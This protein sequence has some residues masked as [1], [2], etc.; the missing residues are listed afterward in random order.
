[1]FHPVAVGKPFLRRR[2]IEGAGMLC[3]PALQIGFRDFIPIIEDDD[4]QPFVER[5]E[6]GAL[7]DDDVAEV[8]AVLNDLGADKFCRDL[9]E[10][11]AALNYKAIDSLEIS[12][13]ARAECRELTQ[14]LLERDY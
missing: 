4:G 2:V 10:E 8:F 13:D 7:G 11:H 5:I 6:R 3:Q 9:A 12:P 1:M 14:F